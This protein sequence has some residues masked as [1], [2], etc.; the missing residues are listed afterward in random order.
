[1]KKVVVTGA[2]GFI[3]RNSLRLLKNRGFD[4]YGISLKQIEG[5]FDG[6]Q[7]HPVD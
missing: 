7:I 1:M 6:L 5:K 2:T 3:G 4:V